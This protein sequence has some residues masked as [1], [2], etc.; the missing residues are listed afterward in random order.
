MQQNFDRILQKIR[1]NTA[2]QG[3]TV[4]NRK[5]CP[6]NFKA[7]EVLVEVTAA[8]APAIFKSIEVCCAHE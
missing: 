5:I 8:R 1:R 6:V 4:G 3:R 7:E 2:V